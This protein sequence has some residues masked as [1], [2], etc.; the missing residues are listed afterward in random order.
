M[1]LSLLHKISMYF[2]ATDQFVFRTISATV[3]S[4]KFPACKFIKNTSIKERNE[5]A[6]WVSVT[7]SFV[8]EDN[9]ISKQQ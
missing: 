4:V 1:L 8:Q 9:G 5:W 2:S 7:F 3:V 6:F